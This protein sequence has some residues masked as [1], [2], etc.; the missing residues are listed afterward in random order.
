MPLRNLGVN[1]MQSIEAFLNQQ[2]SRTV[3][4]NSIG[5]P[6]KSLILKFETEQAGKLLVSELICMGTT[7]VHFSTFRWQ[8]NLVATQHDRPNR[9]FSDDMDSILVDQQNDIRIECGNLMLLIDNRL[10]VPG[11]DGNPT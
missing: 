1:Q 5:P 7:A 6:C 9:L 11:I 10:K 3:Y 2:R 8:S 4:L